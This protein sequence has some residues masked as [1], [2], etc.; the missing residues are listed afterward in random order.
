MGFFKPVI[1]V[2]TLGSERP[3]RRLAAYYFVLAII[4][5]GLLEIRPVSG[6]LFPDGYTDHFSQTSDI[7]QDGLTSGQQIQV[8]TASKLV[9]TLDVAAST[10]LL[11]LSTLA[12]MLPVTWVYMSDHRARSHQ[13]AIVETLLVLPMI[14]AGIVFVVRNSLALAFSLAGVVAAVRFRNSLSDTR[15]MVFIFLA[16]AIGFATG[17]QVLVVAAVLSVLFNL[18]MLLSWR[19]DFG[20]NALDPAAASRWKKPLDSLATKDD[21]GKEIPDRD[22]VLALTPNKVDILAEKFDRVRSLL[23]NDAKK[24]RYNAVVSITTS[25]VSGVQHFVED[26]LDDYTRRWRLDEVVT[27]AGDVSELFYLVRPKKSVTRDGLI[28]AIRT[29]VNGALESVDMEIG[30]AVAVENGQRRAARKRQEQRA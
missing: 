6:L 21:Q 7:L 20:R 16:I 8:P 13:Q 9:S 28:T 10:T 4:V 12:L 30:D 17:V 18:V 3:L 25:D 11:F 23:G 5:L 29:R 15:D 2:L 19:Y 27:N 1:D 26:V 22:L 24:P 14:V